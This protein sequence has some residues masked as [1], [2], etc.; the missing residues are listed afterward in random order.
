MAEIS[1]RGTTLLVGP[2]VI[3]TIKPCG[4]SFEA[5]KE[6]IEILESWTDMDQEERTAY[7]IHCPV[8]TELQQERVK[9]LEYYL[10]DILEL[11]LFRGCDYDTETLEEYPR[12]RH[13]RLFLAELEAEGEKV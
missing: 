12:V 8:C 1:R 10:K 11:L 5:R 7:Q 13:A 2:G 3:A 6:D 9:K 4:H